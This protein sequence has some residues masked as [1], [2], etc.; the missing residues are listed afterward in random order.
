MD[1]ES[2]DEAA[3]QMP[4]DPF[5]DSEAFLGSSGLDFESYFRQHENLA[6][7]KNFPTPG[8]LEPAG[9]ADYAQYGKLSEAE[10]IHVE[11]CVHCRALLHMIEPNPQNLEAFRDQVLASR[12][13]R[14]SRYVPIQSSTRPSLQW[15][16]FRQYLIAALAV[17]IVSVVIFAFSGK[18]KNPGSETVSENPTGT[19][20]ESP[21]APLQS[22]QVKPTLQTTSRQFHTVPLS[23][24]IKQNRIDPR[25]QQTAVASVVA[26]AFDPH[27][28]D[29][30]KPDE[31][32]TQIQSDYIHLHESW[33]R[34]VEKVAFHQG[35]TDEAIYKMTEGELCDAF[36]EAVSGSDVKIEMSR[37]SN[38]CRINY[39]MAVLRFDPRR[40]VLQARKSEKEL[41]DKNGDAALLSQID[42]HV[43]FLLGSLLTAVS[44]AP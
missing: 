42:P 40:T 4:F 36:A 29:L 13:E 7:D 24:D 19:S 21:S 6:F 14:Q 22:G 44:E 31:R 20:L 39:G 8:C 2:E 25:S 18:G 38:T 30:F 23:A 37:N 28:N 15:V 5:D 16:V 26:F 12:A 1:I 35:I 41:A 32:P 17:V 27:V 34:G 3:Q 9:I 11:S 33:T 10:Q 43:K